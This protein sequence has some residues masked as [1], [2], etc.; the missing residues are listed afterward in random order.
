[1]SKQETYLGDGC[2]ASF[3]GYQ[4]WLRS[5]REAGDHTI[6]LEPETFIALMRFKDALANRSNV[7]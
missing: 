3:D 7:K 4:I 5:P 6:A 2:Y 1:M